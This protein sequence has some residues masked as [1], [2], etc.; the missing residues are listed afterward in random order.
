MQADASPSAVERS[1]EVTVPEP[2]LNTKKDNIRHICL[3]LSISDVKN[4]IG[5]DEMIKA[6]KS[7]GAGFEQMQQAEELRFSKIKTLC[8]EHYEDL[9]RSA[10]S[11]FSDAQV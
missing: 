7:F 5:V 2:F 9:A 1:P 8:M 11:N 10:S 6:Y 3:L 4:Q